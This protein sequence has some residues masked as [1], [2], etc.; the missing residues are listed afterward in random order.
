MGEWSSGHQAERNGVEK[1]A[2]VRKDIS[3]D[4]SFYE[5]ILKPKKKRSNC[6]GLSIDLSYDRKLNTEK[7]CI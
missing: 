4:A 6:F 7:P 1:Q 2:S 5:L 3:T